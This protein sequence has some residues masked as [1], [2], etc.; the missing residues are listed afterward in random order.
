ML[1]HSTKNESRKKFYPLLLIMIL[2]FVVGV[3]FAMV[4]PAWQ[5]P[6]EPAHYNYVRQISETG[7]LP[8]LEDGDYDQG[9]IV[10]KIMPPKSRP[11]FSLDSVQ[12]EDHQPP[13]FYLLATFV[14][15]SFNGSLLALRIFSLCVS[16]ISVCLTY[17]IALQVFPDHSGVAAFATAFVAFLPQHMYMSAGF[18]NDSLSEVLIV[19]TILVAVRNICRS[20]Q[21]EKNSTGVSGEIQLGLTAGLCFITKAQAYVALPI[22]L[23]GTVVSTALQQPA[24]SSHM[25]LVI[26]RLLI[27]LIVSCLI[28]LPWWIHNI[29]TYGGVDFLGLQKHN[30]VVRGQLTTAESISNHGLPS[31]LS[32]MA[33]N[34]FKSYWA[35]FGWMSTPIDDRFYLTFLILCTLSVVL[36]FGWR[37]YGQSLRMKPHGNQVP[38]TPGL[39]Q[40]PYPILTLPQRQILNLFGFVF[41]LALLGFVWY[42]LQFVQYQGRYLYAGIIPVAMAVSLG[43]HFSVSRWRTLRQWLWLMLT[44]ALSVLDLYLLWKV[45]LPNL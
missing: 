11:D 19:L 14:F 5:I 35:D 13:L 22:A 15:K 7:R 38:D 20:S 6:D 1:T 4:T 43:W 41:I 17:L 30:E 18:N 26:R 44:I 33:Q 25:R 27:V 28:G 16:A 40:A 9:L 2:Y 36:Y 8:I 10:N 24:G 32:D 45:I 29:S 21:R 34:T 12:Y 23:Y 37:V 31:L 3:Q 42:N 39:S